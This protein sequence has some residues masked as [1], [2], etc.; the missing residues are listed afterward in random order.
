MWLRIPDEAHEAVRDLL[1]E[2]FPDAFRELSGN[3]YGGPRGETDAKYLDAAREKYGTDELEFD[4]D[5]VVSEGLAAGAFVMG[6][7]WIGSDEAG[8]RPDSGTDAG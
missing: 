4:D 3:Y 7:R 6:W 2:K 8:I 5:A 1:R